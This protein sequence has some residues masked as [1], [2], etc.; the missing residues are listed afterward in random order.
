MSFSMMPRICH[1]TKYVVLASVAVAVIWWMNKG[2]N[3][4]LFNSKLSPDGSFV[5]ENY[6]VDECLGECATGR[7]DI[8]NLRNGRSEGFSLPKPMPGIFFRWFDA[9]HLVIFQDDSS[10]VSSISMPRQLSEISI[11]YETYTPLNAAT[12]AAQARRVEK[13]TISASTTSATFTKAS[14]FDR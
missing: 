6:L 9:N 10:A 5:V 11:A 12:A 14:V 13:R 1:A 4:M 2:P 7:I 8:R 3:M